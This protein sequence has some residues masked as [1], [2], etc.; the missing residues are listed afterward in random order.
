LATGATEAGYEGTTYA[1]IGAVQRGLGAEI[2][3][4]KDAGKDTTELDASLTSVNA[5]RE[6]M[7]KGETLRGL[8]LTTYGFSIFGERAALAATICFIA[9]ALLVVLS[10]AGLIHF[11]M[12][13][14]DKVVGLG[15]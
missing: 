9:A 1:T 13:P 5:L 3:A 12:T 15:H 11:K 4:A 10:L 6:T 8:L 14:V 7:F 2:Q